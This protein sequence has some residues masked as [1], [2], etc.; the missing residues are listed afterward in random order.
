M[1]NF[2]RGLRVGAL[3]AGMALLSACAQLSE[4]DRTLLQQARAD[5]AAAQAAADRAAQAADRAAAAATQAAD[6]ASN[7]QMA[8]E[9]QSRMVQQTMRK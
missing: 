7:A 5:S 6:A 4:E 8:A 9:R 2:G 1:S 3:L